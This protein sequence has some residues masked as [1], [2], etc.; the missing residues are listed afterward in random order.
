MKISEL[1]SLMAGAIRIEVYEY[2]GMFLCDPV[3]AGEIDSMPDSVREKQIFQILP[4]FYFSEDHYPMSCLKVEF[5]LEEV[6]E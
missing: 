2:G 3:Y 4:G 5:R 1:V 6:A